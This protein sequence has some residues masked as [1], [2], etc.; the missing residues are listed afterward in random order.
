[1]T[2]AIASF[3]ACAQANSFAYFAAATRLTAADIGGTPVARVWPM[4]RSS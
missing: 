1:M 2:S 4:R 3:I